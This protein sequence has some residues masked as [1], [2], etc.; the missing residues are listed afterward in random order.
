MTLSSRQSSGPST[1][2]PEGLDAQATAQHCRTAVP[3]A[4]PPWPQPHQQHLQTP[5]GMQCYGVHWLPREA[6]RTATA[7]QVVK[8]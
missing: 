4:L 5:T 1:G 3:P 6:R 2:P 7:A 8:S